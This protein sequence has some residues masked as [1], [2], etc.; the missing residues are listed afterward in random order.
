MWGLATTVILDDVLCNR[1][2][3]RPDTR[4]LVSGL[5]H[6]SQFAELQTYLQ[7]GQAGQAGVWNDQKRRP[8]TLQK[9]GAGSTDS[10]WWTLESESVRASE[11]L[12]WTLQS[13][14]I[15]KLQLGVRGAGGSQ[16]GLLAITTRQ[17]FPVTNWV[18]NCYKS[19]WMSVR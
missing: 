8:P 6:W 13:W 16:H 18:N 9:P 3:H 2:R 15:R 4:V 7:V 10:G 17:Y 14:T 1:W 5:V 12:V 19:N 11:L